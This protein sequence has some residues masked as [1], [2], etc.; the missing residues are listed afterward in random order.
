MTQTVKVC[1]VDQ[2]LKEV[3]KKFRFRKSKENAAIILKMNRE[4]L[5]VVIEET[6]EDCTVEEL[7]EELPE[8]QPRFVLYSYAYTHDDGRISYPLCFIF[9][10]PP[11]C[12][13]ELQ[14]M[15][16]GSMNNL[17]QEIQ[18]TKV[19]EIRDIEELTEDWLKEKLVFFR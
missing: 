5:R 9:V 16:A 8:H 18:A 17:V 6:L 15:Y 11:G 12:K 14:M 3:L 4:D 7:C 2:E 19:F 10:S 13:P 1:D